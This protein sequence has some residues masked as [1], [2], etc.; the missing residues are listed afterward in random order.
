MGAVYRRACNRAGPSLA[1]TPGVQHGL[2][3]QAPKSTKEQTTEKLP[4]H[5]QA[6]HMHTF[7]TLPG[8]CLE[9]NDACLSYSLNV[10]AYLC[11]RLCI[12][13]PGLTPKRC[14]LR[15]S[16]HGSTRTRSVGGPS[17]HIVDSKVSGSLYPKREELELNPKV[18][19]VSS[20]D[21]QGSFQACQE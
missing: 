12:V 8:Q 5:P 21:V 2:F 18:R 10:P 16:S 14:V 15:A 19:Q 1:S 7:C 4:K 9:G 13:V 3:R 11:G 6:H 20:N 17:G